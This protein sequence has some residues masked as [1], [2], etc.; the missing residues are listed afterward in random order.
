MTGRGIV[1]AQLIESRLADDGAEAPPD[2]KTL[3]PTTYFAPGKLYSRSEIH[4]LFGGQRQGGI[5]TP[6]RH[7]VVFLF[8]S[9]D[10]S[11]YG[12]RDGWKQDGLYHYTGEGQQGDMA[13]ERGNKAIRDHTIDGKSLLLF[14]KEGENRRFVGYMNCVGFFHETLTDAK[15]ATRRGIIFVLAPEQQSSEDL[16]S[17]PADVP[18]DALRQ[19]AYQA[20][21]DDD[22]GQDRRVT[23]TRYLKRSAIIKTYVLDRAKGFCDLCGRPGPFRRPD[24]SL[25]LESHHIR[26][27]SD[28]GPDD[29]RFMAACCPECHRR[30]HHA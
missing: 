23:K 1:A 2:E 18:S 22:T 5:S 15:G 19:A 21:K 14:E 10:G 20:V 24:G 25:Y 27:R 29:P 9:E 26:R 17:K 28:D 8:S 16:P 4:R 6:R 30:A 11:L 12:Y 13:F 3:D 7:A